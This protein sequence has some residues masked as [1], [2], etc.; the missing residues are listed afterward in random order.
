MT[1]KE[2]AKKQVELAKKLMNS[3]KIIKNN[4]F[5]D[6]R[7]V[8]INENTK[9][10]NEFTNIIKNNLDLAKTYPKVKDNLFNICITDSIKI[11]EG[12]K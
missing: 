8:S 9:A 5:G 7:T 12:G 4:Y 1:K 10:I 11:V 3:Y 6:I 2:Q